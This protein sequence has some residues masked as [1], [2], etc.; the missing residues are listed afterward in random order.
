MKAFMAISALP[1]CVAV[2]VLAAAGAQAAVT[3]SVTLTGPIDELLP[4]LEHLREM[5]VGAA[6]PG[7][8][9][10][11]LEMHSV[12]T[13]EGN[14]AEGQPAPAEPPAPPKPA[15]P[16]LTGFTAEPSPARA[17]EK[18]WISILVANG[19]GKVDTVS[20]TIGGTNTPFELYD[21]GENGDPV[22]GDGQWS[23]NI[24][25]DPQLPAGPAPV[26]IVAFD[27]NGQP[28]KVTDASGQPVDLAT[29]VTLEVIK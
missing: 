17:G 12:A 5:G 23:A 6:Q 15:E 9:A 19:V 20:A 18:V 28:V 2:V 7:G 3:V 8:E 25:L 16:S 13:P 22:A 1:L 21:N 29:T 14:A 27:A 10:L 24:I 11:K 4:I 26:H